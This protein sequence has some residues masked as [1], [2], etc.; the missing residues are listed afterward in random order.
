MRAVF[1][2]AKVILEG[3][4]AYLAL[5]VPYRDAQKF[6]GEMKPRKYVV[7]IKEYRPRRS[8][9]ANAYLWL[10]LGRL[11]AKLS[12]PD[13][14]VTP[15]DIYREAIRGVGDNYD[16]TPI[17][18]NALGHWTANWESHGPGWLCDNLGPSKHPGYTNVMNYYGSSVYDKAQMARL[19]DIVVDE[20][21]EQGIET[22]TPEELARL[23]EE[24]K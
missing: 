16:I 3:A 11:A 13:A 4:D 18:D 7:E 17:R 21:K 5:R 19:I 24:W 6:V 9:D 2:A 1:S 20:C 15:E 23:T 12:M 8:L 14:P 22:M 10:L